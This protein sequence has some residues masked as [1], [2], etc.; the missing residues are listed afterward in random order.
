[1]RIAMIAPFGIRPKG[2]LLARMLPL[3]QAL[4]RR[5]HTVAIVAP[6]VHN[7]ADGGTT[8]DY[9]GVT[10]T[11]TPAPPIGGLPAA[12]WHIVA[13][14]QSARRLR[15]DII[16]LFKPKG[17]GGLAVLARGRVPLVVDCD[18][19]EGAGGW[20]DLLPYPPPAKA[21]FAWQERDLPRRAGAVTVV[22][23]TLETLVWA[24][25]VPPQR[26]FYLPNGAA[27][28]E[29]PLPQ[30]TPHPTIVL[31]TRFWELDLDEV[32][33]A[34]AIIYRVRPDTRL[35]LIGK[36]E[37]GEEQRLLALAAAQGWAAMIDN[38]G[39][40][41]PA[42]IPQLLA[43][44]DVAL[45]PIRDTLVNRAR[46][47]AKLVELMAAGL[48]IVASDVGAARDY[49]APDAGILV[50]AGDA[51]ALASSTIELLTDATARARLRTAVIAAARRLDWNNLA[52]IA[53]AAYRQAGTHSQ[54]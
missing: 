7:P 43:S 35:L 22:S 38:R 51:Q 44:A 37:R 11:H 5:S 10:V 18:D 15:P 27:P 3:A 41:E 53:E 1:M 8:R 50:P 9:A 42:A 2:T 20:N 16:H 45:A 29:P 52:P 32:A 6:P 21:L 40:Q 33:A 4:R 19:W 31:Y 26:V 25:G 28:T 34:L 13:L 24:M 54:Q 14:W 47:M 48:P 36:G 17:F 39:W 30:P 46:G 12:L 23:H 49:L